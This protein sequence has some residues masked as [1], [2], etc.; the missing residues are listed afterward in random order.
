MKAKIEIEMDNAAFDEANGFELARILEVA[1][2]NVVN[3]TL[4]G[5][6]SFAMRDYNGNVVGKLIIEE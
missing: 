2:Y 3:E 1:A 4:S 6:E 5:G